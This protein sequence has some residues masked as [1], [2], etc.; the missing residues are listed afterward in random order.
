MGVRG[1]KFETFLEVTERH[2]LGRLFQKYNVTSKTKLRSFLGVRL[3]MI[4]FLISMYTG[5]RKSEVLLLEHGC[6]RTVSIDGLKS[7]FIRGVANKRGREIVYE[8]WVTIAKAGKW[9]DL[10]SR[11]SKLKKEKKSNLFDERIIFRNPLNKSS[12]LNLMCWNVI[13]STLHDVDK[14]RIN[15]RDLSELKDLNPFRDW[16]EEEKFKIDELWPVALH[17][18]RRTLAVYAA[19][20]GLV[21]LPCLLYTSD[22]A[23][24]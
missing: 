14:Y 6:F 15:E 20:S 22:A 3:S 8:D 19:E 13:S 1:S 11:I 17:Q 24:E 21:S 23:D 7:S 5:M 9:I 4:V 2:G 16:K 10:A 18:F 12:R